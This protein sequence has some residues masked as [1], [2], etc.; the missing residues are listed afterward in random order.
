[1]ALASCTCKI[2]KELQAS[3]P[4][5]LTF[6]SAEVG[7]SRRL[8]ECGVHGRPRNPPGAQLGPTVASLRAHRCRL[9]SRWGARRAGE[10]GRSLRRRGPRW[11]RHRPP[12]AAG[13]LRV[14]ATARFRRSSF[15][16]MSGSLPPR[17][18][19]ARQRLKDYSSRPG[20][21][22]ASSSA[23]S[24]FRTT[25]D[26]RCKYL[27]VSSESRGGGI[28]S[29]GGGGQGPHQGRGRVEERPG[30][31]RPGACRGARFGGGGSK[32]SSWKDLWGL[33]HSHLTKEMCRG[34]SPLSS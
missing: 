31:P 15:S 13:L 12:G 26:R 19:A 29:G 4:L 20:R 9:R 34:L 23:V 2:R 8:Q 17:V 6:V 30:L 25:R 27:P 33:V 14:T 7:Y 5:F 21:P 24:G 3:P 18:R 11:R 22:P 1:M 10:P 32:L 28:D 16:S